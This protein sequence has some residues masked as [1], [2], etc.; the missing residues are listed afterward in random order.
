MKQTLK[1]QTTII[2]GPPIQQVYLVETS[3]MVCFY[4]TLVYNQIKQTFDRRR[5][6]KHPFL[7]SSSAFIQPAGSGFA[8]GQGPAP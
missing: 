6:V 1:D 7:H 2:S 3:K 4:P 8:P 5:C